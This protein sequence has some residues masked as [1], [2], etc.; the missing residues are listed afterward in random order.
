MDHP[1]Q[2]PTRRSPREDGCIQGIRCWPDKE[3][4]PQQWPVNMD[5]VPPTFDIPMYRT[6]KAKELAGPASRQRATRKQASR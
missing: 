2:D 4:Q 5:D 6:I 3:I 1:F